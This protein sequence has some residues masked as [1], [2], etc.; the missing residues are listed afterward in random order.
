M[1]RRTLLAA[2]L[3][4]APLAAPRAQG[5]PTRPIRIVVGF[6]PGGGSDLVARPLAQKMQPLLGQSVLVENRGGANGNLGLAEVAKSAADGYTIGHVNNSV[7]AVNPLL[8]A[9]LPFDP[10]RDLTP[11]G[12]VTAG[13]LFVMVPADLPARDLRELVALAKARPGQLNFGSGGAGGITHLGF[14]LFRKQSGA[15]IVHVPYRGSAPALQDMLGGRI[16]LMIDGFNLAK[17]QVDAGRV[18]AIAFLG[19]ERHPAL[20]QVPT[21]AEQ[22]FPDLVVPG[23][24]GFVA[25]AGTPEAVLA[26]L[27]EAFRVAVADP[28]IQANFMTQGTQAV[29]RGRTEMAHMIREETA[30]WAPIIQELGIRLD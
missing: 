1:H 18:R 8:Y 9:N 29:F 30:R 26:R 11:I 23:W 6:P 15:E 27:E 5:F 21:A 2:A 25:P 17:A 12:T 24:Q 13:A 10:A 7:I 14:E 20:N 3:A 16:Q 22:G 4:V 28:D 19:R